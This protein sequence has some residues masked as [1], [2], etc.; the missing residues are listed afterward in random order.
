[1]VEKLNEVRDVG[2]LEDGDHAGMVALEFVLDECQEA[3][4]HVCCSQA[5]KADESL[6]TD[7]DPW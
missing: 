2:K 5:S 1:M 6:L 4:E 7:A 3:D